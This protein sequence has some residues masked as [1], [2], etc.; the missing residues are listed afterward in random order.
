LSCLPYLAKTERVRKKVEERINHMHTDYIPSLI[1][2]L[3]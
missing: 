3:K 1:N 2:R